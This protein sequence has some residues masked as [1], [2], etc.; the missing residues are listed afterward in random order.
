MGDTGA[1]VDPHSGS[2]QLSDPRRPLEE[3]ATSRRMEEGFGLPP[4]AAH[5]VPLNQAQ[6]AN[7]AESAERMSAYL[8]QMQELLWF[9]KSVLVQ[10]T[11]RLQ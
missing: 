1:S 8:Q 5:G 10:K 11:R 6:A 4:L 3:K 2:S 7:A 9:E